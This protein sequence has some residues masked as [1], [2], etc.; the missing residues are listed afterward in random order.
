MENNSTIFRRVF[1]LYLQRIDKQDQTIE[2]GFF[3]ALSFI[4]GF[5]EVYAIVL[6]NHA[7]CR[8]LIN[9]STVEAFENRRYLIF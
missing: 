3:F 7:L 9:T 1:R 8:L 2:W 5:N 4:F 6:S